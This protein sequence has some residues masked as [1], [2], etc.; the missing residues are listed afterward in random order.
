MMDGRISLEN[1]SSPGKLKFTYLTE[2]ILFCQVI[3]EF[4]IHPSCM[5]IIWNSPLLLLVSF[6]LSVFVSPI[7][8]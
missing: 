6:F 2:R 4:Y 1:N 5:D 3:L 7:A 8:G